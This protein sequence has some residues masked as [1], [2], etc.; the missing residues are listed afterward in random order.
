MASPETQ[1]VDPS[2]PLGMTT[3]ARDDNRGQQNGPAFIGGAV[4]SALDRIRTCDLR[5]RRP[6]LYPAELR[7]QCGDRPQDVK[8]TDA[9]IG[10]QVCFPLMDAGQTRGPR[11]TGP[12]RDTSSARE[13][14]PRDRVEEGERLRADEQR[15]AHGRSVRG[16]PANLRD[17]RR[18][19]GLRAALSA[20]VDRH[21][22]WWRR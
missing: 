18:C 8:I 6:T 5:L 4:P 19:R 15:V 22:H 11:V 10:G 12:P 16:P 3:G 2:L 21:G 13:D 17:R 20:R 14:L 1:K 7:A 9:S